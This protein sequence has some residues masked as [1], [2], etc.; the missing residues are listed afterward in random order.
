MDFYTNST[1]LVQTGRGLGS[2]IGSISKF[3][4][5][6]TFKRKCKMCFYFSV[7]VAVCAHVRGPQNFCDAGVVQPLIWWARMTHRN[8]LLPTC[9]RIPNFIALTQSVCGSVWVPKIRGRWEPGLLGWGVGD[10]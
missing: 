9:Y 4:D 6:I 2:Y 10:P 3:W 1:F 5:L 7:S 8:T